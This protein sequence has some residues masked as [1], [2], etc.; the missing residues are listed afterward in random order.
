MFWCFIICGR[1]LAKASG[2]RIRVESTQPEAAWSLQLQELS[3]SIFEVACIDNVVEAFSNVEV[4]LCATENMA[5][6]VES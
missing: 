4:D 5:C 3:R 2:H 6:V 1:W